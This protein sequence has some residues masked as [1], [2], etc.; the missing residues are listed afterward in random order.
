MSAW[1]Y[2]YKMTPEAPEH[3]HASHTGHRWLDLVLGVS[4]M[5]VSVVSLIVAVA[6]G[7]T[8]ER[9]ADANARMVEANSWPFIEFETHNADEHG[10][11]DV[12]LV[13]VNEGVGPARIE[14]FELWWNGKPMSSR[15]KL[16]QAC[17]STTP[18][19]S[20]QL[21]TAVTSVGLA[22]PRILRAGEHVDFFEMPRSTGNSDVWAKFNIERGKI[23][24]RV[25]YCSV[26]DECWV[27]S[28]GTGLPRQGQNKV[29]H[30]DRVDSCPTPAIPF[31]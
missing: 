29:T 3:H 8:M 12:R 5:F 15:G 18:A 24:A 16:M 9:M 7:R 22:S 1:S 23:A 27:H 26:F 31:Q 20:E 11:A 4:A 25:C 14:T 28:A 6:H 21:K 17:C 13:L 2:S 19:E 10:D 30:P